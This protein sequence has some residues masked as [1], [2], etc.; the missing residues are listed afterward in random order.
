MLFTGLCFVAVTALVKFL[1]PRIP[2]AEAAFLR[3]ALGLVFLLPMLRPMLNTRFTGRLVG[4]FA[5]RGVLHAG[6]VMLWFFAMTQIPLAELTALNYLSPVFVTI[7]AAVFLGEKLAIRRIAAVTVALVGAI[8]ILRPG[9]REVSPGHLAMICT[10]TVFGGSYL[11][12][13]VLADEVSPSVVVGMLSIWVTAGLAPFAA[14]VWVAP[15]LHELAI[16]FAVAC[17]ATTGHFTMTLALRAAP[18]MVTQ[19]VTFLQL[20]WAM[21]LGAAVFGESLDVWVVFGGGLI[22]ASITFITWREAV[23]RRR[24]ITPITPATKV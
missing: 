7:G 9:F 22:L 12:A 19:P 6:G 4:L 2:A 15:N 1:G 17:F 20:V 14:A 21:L 10:A 16:L 23:V 8:I 11:L 13:K 18:I 24:S 3:Y 5:L